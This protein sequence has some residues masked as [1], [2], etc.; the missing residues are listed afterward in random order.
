MMWGT[1]PQCAKLTGDSGCGFEAVF[2]DNF[3]LF[4]SFAENWSQRLLGL[5]Q[6]YRP[7]SDTAHWSVFVSSLTVKPGKARPISRRSIAA[8]WAARGYLLRCTR[9][10][11]HLFCSSLIRINA[12][13]FGGEMVICAG[14]FRNWIELTLSNQRCGG[15]HEF[16]RHQR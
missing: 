2:I 15:R 3:R 8:C 16:A 6:H 9:R 11:R 14:R 1:K 7:F 10:C 12:G 5:L 4:R 13:S